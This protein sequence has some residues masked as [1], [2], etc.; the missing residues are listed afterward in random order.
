EDDARTRAVVEATLK[1]IET[2]GDAAVREL[3]EKF[4]NYSPES[5][6]LSQEQIDELIA[7]LSERE[8][9]DIKFAQE[10]VMNFAQAQRDSMLDIEVETLP[11][12]ILGHKNIPVQSVGCYVPGGK[13]PMVASAH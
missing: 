1:D 7:S 10:Q 6:R 2:R 13:F 3:S 5:F 11:G 4:D 9:A 12:V 8:L